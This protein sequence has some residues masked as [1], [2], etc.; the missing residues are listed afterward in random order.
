MLRVLSYNIRYNN[1]AD[2]ANAWPRRRDRVASVLHLYHPDL[3]GLQEV[4]HDQLVYLASRLP[5]YGWVGVGR[6]DGD[7]RGEY[8]V[9]FYRRARLDLV[10]SGTFWLSQTPDVPGRMGWDADCVRIVTWAE[11][12]DKETGAPCVHA[13]T[14]FDHRGKRAR[15][16]SAR[17]LRAFLAARPTAMPAIVTGDFNCTEQS[18]TYRTLTEATAADGLPLRDAM[19]IAQAPHHGPSGSLNTQ[20][21]EPLRE[22]I[23]YIF[24]WP[25]VEEECEEKRKIQVQRHAIL[26][27]HWD[28][29][30]PSDH[31]PVLA[32]LRI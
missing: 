8:T 32:D 21:A 7:T 13:N 9:I 15:V 1:P 2:G 5:M 14:H 16:E 19:H 10:R 22:K 28:G 29:C 17:L 24:V 23:D 27:D 25:Q 11:F 30:Y 12:V 3:I 18:E 26:A 6:D 4:L 31:L 20:F